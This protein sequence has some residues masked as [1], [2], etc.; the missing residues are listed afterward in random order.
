VD[1][2]NQGAQSLCTGGKVGTNPAHSFWRTGLG[3]TSVHICDTVNSRVRVQAQHRPHHRAH[4]Q[5]RS[6]SLCWHRTTNCRRFRP[7]C[8]LPPSQL[9]TAC[10]NVMIDRA[11]AVPSTIR[12]TCASCVFRLYASRVNRPNTV[13]I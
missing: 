11:G 12:P 13:S 10:N 2:S 5:K 9:K 6:Y 3:R 7:M 8:A 1:T 4:N